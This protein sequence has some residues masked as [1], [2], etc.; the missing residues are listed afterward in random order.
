MLVSKWVAEDCIS[1]DKIAYIGNF[2]NVMKNMY[3]ATG[4]N[5][6]G[7]T[8]SNIA[9]NIISDKIMGYK[10]IYEDIFK[11]FYMSKTRKEITT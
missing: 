10:N 9:A 7:L 2:S 4:F 6:W 11:S 8:A 3:V 5:K 1:L